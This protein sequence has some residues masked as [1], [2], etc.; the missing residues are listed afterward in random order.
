MDSGGKTGPLTN[1]LQLYC[2]AAV[3]MKNSYVS[4]NVSNYNMDQ[5]QDQF[6][7]IWLKIGQITQLL[8]K[9]HN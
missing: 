1:Q 3:W 7:I 9:L 6:H 2:R 8:V 4:I 5:I